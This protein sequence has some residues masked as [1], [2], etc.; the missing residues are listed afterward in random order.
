[1]HWFKGWKN[2]TIS[3]AT[4]DK[5]SSSKRVRIP[6][7]TIEVLNPQNI[8]AL[9]RMFIANGQGKMLVQFQ[10]QINIADDGPQLLQVSS[11][12]T[13]VKKTI[14]SLK[15]ALFSALLRRDS[16]TSFRLCC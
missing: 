12:S 16:Q 7:L 13:L 5:Q 15:F 11:T 3:K 1:L 2:S 9:A 8:G 4:R 10:D 6:H 14:I